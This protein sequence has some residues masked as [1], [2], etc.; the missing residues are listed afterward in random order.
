MFRPHAE[1]RYPLRQGIGLRVHFEWLV[2]SAELANRVAAM[3]ALWKGTGG[4]RE[5]RVE[6]RALLCPR[7]GEGAR[8]LRLR[9]NL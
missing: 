9:R 4:D 8:H 6:L 2:A 7:V 5:L 3:V 1:Q